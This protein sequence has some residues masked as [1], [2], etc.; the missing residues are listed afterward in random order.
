MVREFEG[1]Q[2]IGAVTRTSQS[3]DQI[4]RTLLTEVQVPNGQ[5]VLLPGMYAQ[6]Q[7]ADT[8]PSPPLLVPG[9]SVIVTSNGLQVAVLQDLTPQDRTQLQQRLQPKKKLS[10][11]EAEQQQKK[12]EQELQ[13]ARKIAIRMVQ[14][15]RDYG[16]E[17]EIT[18][19]LQG[20][21]TVV[22]NP[23]DET[24]DGVIVMPRQAP[25]VPGE[26]GPPSQGEMQGQAGGIGSPSMAAPTLGSQQ[27]QQGRQSGK[28]TGKDDNKKGD[29]NK[30]DKK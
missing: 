19:G 12:I 28:S 27:K 15:G 26:G 7:F 18:A 6:V 20:G 10:G 2:F 23:G 24:R 21:E 9:D 11:K 4:T 5:N 29:K 14:L 25:P 17:T 3:L 16:T 13:Q 30:G 22:V 1:R 8:R